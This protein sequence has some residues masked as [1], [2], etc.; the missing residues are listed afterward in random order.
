MTMETKTGPIAWMAR[1]PV[2]A[3][4]LMIVILVG[5][6]V[7]ALQ[8]KQEVF[9]E[10]DLDMVSVS[11]P[12]PGATPDDVEQ[13]IVRAVEEAVRGIDGV[14]RV[15]STSGEGVGSVSVELLLD[16]D[17]DKVLGDVKNAVD[18]ITVFPLEAEKPQVTLASR[19]S[20]VISLI[21][22][23]DLELAQLHDLAER[24][25]ADLLSKP[26][27]TQV[28]LQGVPPLEL[29]IEISREQL[30]ALGLTI[31]EVARIVGAASVELPGGSVKTD[32]GE[33]LVRVADRALEVEDFAN[34]PLRTTVDG[35]Y[36]R[37][38]DVAS[39]RDG[40]AETDQSNY[41]NGER[42][43]RLVAYRVGDETPSS[44][45]KAVNGYVDE[46]RDEL[47]A[48][49]E[50]ATWDD[51]S[52]KLTDRITLL[53]KNGA[54]GLILV[55]VTLTLLLKLR[56]AFWV[57]LGLPISFMGGFMLMPGA[58]LSINMITLFAFIVTL[59]MVVDD[60]IVV[61][62]NIYARM[63]EGL[64]PIDAAI[65]GAR[66]MA[67]PVTFAILTSIAAFAPLFFVPGTMG[68]I[69][70]F[71]P[72]VVSAVLVFSLVESFFVLPAHLGH[73]RDKQRTG[74]AGFIDGLSAKAGDALERFTAQRYRPALQVVMRHRYLSLSAG[75]AVFF[76]A[77]GMVAS[78]T[79]PFNF[80]PSLEGDVVM[81]QARLPYGAPMADTVTVRQA[82][83]HAANSALAELG[84]PEHSRGMYTMVA[85]GPAQRFG[86]SESG[87]HLVTIEQ[88]LVPSDQR[89]FSS[90]E[91]STLWD[92]KTPAL[93][94]ADAV[95]FES[96]VGPGAGAAVDLQ[97]SHTDTGVL[98][99]A[100]AELAVAL[101]GY[102]ELYNVE[103]G[104]AA[105]KPR[106]DYDPL[107]RAESLGLDT[108]QVGRQLRSAFF[109]AEAI[110]EQRGR[111]EL[112]VM[113]RLPKDQRGS[114]YDLEALRI[115]TP[116]GGF[117]PLG[118]VADIDRN[119]APTSIL[120]EDGR[121][122]VNVSAE[123]TAQV[124]SSR[125][126]RDDL[127]KKIL[128]KIVRKY[129]G[130]DVQFVG[131]QRSQ[132]EAFGSLG[133]N[134]LV[135]LFVIYGLLAIPFRSYVQPLIIM[136]A[137]PFGFVGAV[138][139]HL[140]LGY[141]LSLISM[142]GIIALS[143]VV[144]NDS[145]V[146]IDAVNK[147]RATGVSAFEAATYG[148]VRRMRPIIL[149]SLTTFF[150]LA[151]MILETSVGARF[152]IPMAISL[153]FGVLFATFIILL[154]V[155]C[156]YLVVEDLRGNDVDDTD[157]QVLVSKS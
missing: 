47:P 41:Y 42:A 62:E 138:L 150:G 69:F 136:S 157:G 147:K 16:A 116:K 153:G 129:P 15:N 87:S 78:G 121:R 12:Y 26:E 125:G 77:V 58:D 72:F 37:L 29:A 56:L 101:S 120:R 19:R 154:L 95:V 148:G 132:Q 20:T 145:L 131:Q 155:P 32:Q 141:S 85:E 6:L 7:G 38:G 35:A 31:D 130:L 53:L 135:A 24:A 140:I 83:E 51:D 75:V 149:T 64:E 81:V 92:A 11:V 48:H 113:V 59:G 97:L 112:R 102:E 90:Q 50:V 68:K 60:A 22:A 109:G 17:P 151:P 36:L 96:S 122:I 152:L 123:L 1:N 84:G 115:R 25:R 104:F 86:P 34:I 40:Y 142:F 74:I 2:A 89:D 103:N 18:R 23:A 27:I 82:L 9:P 61:G 137:I 70:A 79:V 3:N 14:K 107:P 134:Y 45:S 57:S 66:E 52:E 99:R 93:P 108:A 139:G 10:F 71:F 105:G 143:G 100:A 44:V 5:G 39:I 28:D 128:P 49:V 146:L 124:K 94:M 46:L 98:E 33:V 144:V 118:A 110:R 126:V 80:F 91:F 21:V 106:L 63:Q 73:S 127:T 8:V 30:E 54:I 114:E 117:V 76:V 67:M 13:G 4:L 88:A 156:L 65:V 133:K 111:N 55:V 43:V 119:R